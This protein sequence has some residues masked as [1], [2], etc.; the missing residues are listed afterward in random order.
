[1]PL[2]AIGEVIGQIGPGR[3][4]HPSLPALIKWIT[5]RCRDEIASRCARRRKSVGGCRVAEF[6]PPRRTVEKAHDGA[7]P[8]YGARGKVRRF[9]IMCVLIPCLIFD[10]G[11]QIDPCEINLQCK[12]PLPNVIRWLRIF[13]FPK[14]NAPG[15]VYE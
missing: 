15:P 1:M 12:H 10:P 4:S 7:S 6:W 2:A 9:A 14:R 3:L 13:L 8:F 11:L 5:A